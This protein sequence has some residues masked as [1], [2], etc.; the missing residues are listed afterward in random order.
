M[1]KQKREKRSNSIV[2]QRRE[3]RRRDLR[4]RGLEG[5]GLKIYGQR[6]RCCQSA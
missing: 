3:E 1:E 2:I 4:K 6:W 5:G